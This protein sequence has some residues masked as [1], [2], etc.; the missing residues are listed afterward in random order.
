MNKIKLFTGIIL[1]AVSFAAKAQNLSE[2]NITQLVNREADSMQFRLQLDSSQRQAI[3]SVQEL[4]YDSVRA[5][6]AQFGIE[7]RTVVYR[8]LEERR[9]NAL[10]EI[11]TQPQWQQHLL[12]LQ[13]RKAAI[14]QAIE[15]RRNQ[16]RQN[17]NQ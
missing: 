17:R 9:D 7:E 2:V 3:V 5:I 12:W 15:E 6:P 14:Q 1:L 16:V 13:Q 10:Q 8:R 4:Y 11:L